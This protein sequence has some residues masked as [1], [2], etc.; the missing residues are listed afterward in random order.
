MVLAGHRDT[1]FRFLRELRPGD[2]LELETRRGVRT[3]YRV[4][5]AGIVHE[6]DTALLGTAD[7]DVL[8][9]VTCWPFDAIRPGGTWRYVVVAEAEQGVGPL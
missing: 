9:L 4:A 5:W 7:T 8:T 3:A 1:H 2:A 6:R